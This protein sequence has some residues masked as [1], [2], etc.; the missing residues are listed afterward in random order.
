MLLAV[1]RHA[2]FKAAG[3][4]L[5]L[6]TSTTARRV[7]ALESAVGRTLVVRTTRGAVLEPDAL[8]L[9]ELAES[10]ELGLRAAT[11]TTQTLAGAVRVSAGEGFAQALVQVLAEVRRRTPGLQVELMGEARVADVARREADL[12]VRTVRTTSAVVIERPLGRLRFALYGSK[13]YVGRRLRGPLLKQEDVGR[14]DFIGWLGALER[15]PQ[16]RWLAGLGV[17]AQAFRASTDA[18][19]LEAARQGQGLAVLAELVGDA[20]PTLQRVETDRAPLEVPV[21][22]VFHRALRDVARVRLVSDAIEAAFRR[23]SS[24]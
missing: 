8:P 21:F 18:L 24:R 23:R 16:A 2:S 5:G 19:V 4:A 11:R 22:L 3:V 1:Q 9:V 17:R 15:L 7:E 13:D 14:L 12:A 10:L 6:S 20:E